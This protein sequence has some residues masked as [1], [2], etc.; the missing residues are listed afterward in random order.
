[1]GLRQMKREGSMRSGWKQPGS[2]GLHGVFTTHCGPSREL[3]ALLSPLHSFPSQAPS[4]FNAVAPRSL[5]LR[6]LRTRSPAVLLSPN[7]NRWFGRVA[8]ASHT[9]PRVGAC[10]AVLRGSRAGGAVGNKQALLSF[11][12]RAWS[13]N[14]AVNRT[15]RHR[16]SFLSRV[17]RLPALSLT[18]RD[19]QRRLPSR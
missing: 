1:M 4:R 18:V 15:L 8:L 12:L 5:P 10:A 17:A 11:L 16:A 19:A 13:P 2:S 9:R 7:T 3:P 6:V 14:P